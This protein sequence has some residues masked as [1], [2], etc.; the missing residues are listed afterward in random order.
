MTN[1]KANEIRARDNK[2]MVLI[3]AG[4]FL[5]GSES[6]YHEEKPVHKVSLKSYYIDKYPV[7]NK[8]YKAYCDASG[9]GYP[10]NP[11]WPNMPNYFTN[12]PEYPV[13]N[14]SWEQAK[15][16]G[17]WAGKRLPT[18]EEWEYASRGSLKEADYPWGREEPRENKANYADQ[19]T[20]YAWRDFRHSTGYPYTS[21][22]GSYEPN[23]YGL[24]DMAGNI[25]EWTADWF[26]D[27]TDK[28][29]DTE[30]FRDGWG[31]YRVCRGGCYHSSIFD[32]RISRRRKVLGGQGLISIGFRCVKDIEACHEPVIASEDVHAIAISSEEETQSPDWTRK[33]DTVQVALKDDTE[34]CLGVKMLT[35]KRALHIR[36]LGFTSVEQYVT[37]ET[38]ENCG[39]NS[40]DFSVWDAQVEIIKKAGLKWVPF[41]IAGPAYALPDWYRESR[42]FEGLR[43]LEHNIE[44]KIQSIWDHE[45]YYYI[46]RFLKK[47]ADRYR[48]SGVIESLLLGI[49]GDFGEA[50]FPDWHGNW[51]TQI[52]GLYHSHAG[53]WCNDKFALA[54][55]RKK[56][57][58]KYQ[59]ISRLN[60]TWETNFPAFSSVSFPE[61]TVDGLEGFRVDEHTEAGK[62]K[63]NSNSSRKRWVDFIDWYRGSMT[64]YAGI[65]MKTARKYFPDH[66]VYLCTG[67]NAVP[68]HGS[69][70]ADQCKTAARCHCG[71]RITNEASIYAENF[72]L[73]NWISSA[74]SFY[75]VAFGFEPA[76]K[77]TEKGVVCRIY[78]AA[79]TGAEELH[80]YEENL[81][82]REE[83]ADLFIKNLKYLHQRRPRK[84]IGVFYP[85][86]S[87]VLDTV[88]PAEVMINFG[89][90]RDYSDFRFIDDRTV[91]DGI[92]EDLHYLIIG[93][94]EMFRRKTLDIL[95]NWLQKGGL[96][97]GYQVQELRALEDNR[98]YWDKF[99][100]RK[101]GEKKIGA[102]KSLY[103]PV[104]I[105]SDHLL[106]VIS[107]SELPD[108]P[109]VKDMEYYQQNLCDPMTKFLQQNEYH[110][111]DGVLDFIYAAQ[112]EDHKL[113][114]NVTDGKVTRKITDRN[115]KEITITLEPNTIAEV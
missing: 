112:M 16:Y 62:F 3:P 79:A 77:V 45:F 7:T 72:C 44:T 51:P 55:F 52:P 29:K 105:N 27:Y 69:N 8:E 36:N 101:G 39:E 70:F 32:L 108:K 13:I 19:N 25:W 15:A 78:N 100:N 80:F 91:G 5:M 20:E 43:C 83:K 33:L 103:L 4:E 23:G 47:F 74:G 67:G 106:D 2:E 114:L 81:F 14:I 35:E 92:L 63:K 95:W 110:V 109:L 85:D 9:I 96:L 49:T 42:H 84:D 98:N 76:G 75:Q 115:G 6:G 58:E 56:M 28:I 41:L 22:V 99:F 24:Y 37:W 86:V 21:P 30:S 93:T 48:D 68:N 57:N 113:L 104:V 54:D 88:T 50:I 111:M 11:R 31:G 97:I 60:R 82:D 66:P 71:I 34:L 17:E 89:L 10:E 40:W 18:E 26:F 87:I 38:V 107:R 46:E 64:D 61:I 1:E 73:T 94:G 12:Y 53:Y 65:W 59:E 102:G 90:L